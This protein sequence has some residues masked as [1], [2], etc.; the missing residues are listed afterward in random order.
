MLSSVESPTS[1]PAPA[2]AL[3]WHPAS[4]RGKPIEQSVSYPDPRALER[5]LGELAR[6]PPL[7]SSGEVDELRG[8]IAQTTS[9]KAFLLQ[10]GDCVERFIDCHEAVITNKLKILLQMSVILTHST[11][12]PVIRIGRIAGQYAK[13]RSQATETVDGCEVLTYRGDSI[14]D[15]APTVA[16]R[17]PD[18]DRLLQAYFLAATTL[19]YIRSVIDGGFADLHQPYNWNLYGIERSAQWPEYK[20]TV[21]RILDAIHFMESF[22]GVN[23]DKLQRVSFYTS[24]EALHL[25]YEEALTRFDGR[26][27][28]YYNLGAHMLWVGDRTRRPDGAHAEYLRG[29]ANPVG[30]KVGPGADPDELVRLLDVINPDRGAGRI[31]LI[32]RM[33]RERVATHLPPVCRAVHASGHA[34]AWSCDPM[35]GNTVVVDGRKTRRFEAILEDLRA[36][37]ACLEACG[38][39]LGGVHF[40]LTGDDVSEC[41]GGS[42]ASGDHLG[43]N[44]QTYCDP[45]LN[46]DQSLE[47]AF[48]IANMLAARRGRA[49]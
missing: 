23:P 45:R 5:V 41:I 34:V 19:N 22:G 36:T 8:Q 38:S 46:Y 26:R 20:A 37:F 32:T 13:P 1:C 35:H 29:I 15:F 16:G 9:G 40:E 25:P 47:M 21:E 33:G 4:W 18:P 39:T 24:H 43:R 6:R 10:G 44:Y 48:L 7:V 42:V 30:V 31:T 3:S 14:H 17:T 11:R 27:G 12:C 2:L 49:G 28:L